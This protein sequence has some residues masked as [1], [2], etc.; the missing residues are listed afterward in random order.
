M[1]CDQA[2]LE[3]SLSLLSVESRNLLSSLLNTKKVLTHVGP[4]GITRQRDW[5]GL[6][7]LANITNELKLSIDT[8]C[9]DKVGKVLELWIDMNDG[10]AT[11][12]NLL[13]HLE[14][15]DRFDVQDDLK[16]LA[17]EDKLLDDVESDIITVEDKT[18]GAPQ[19][20][21][22]YVLYAQEDRE[23]FEKLRKNVTDEGFS[24]CSEDNLLPGYASRYQPLSRLMLL[25]CRHII[26]I[27]SPDFLRTPALKFFMNLAQADGITN[28][29]NLKLIPVMFRECV[30][31]EHLRFYHNLRY[32]YPEDKAP[33]NFWKKL[34]DTLGPV[35]LNSDQTQ[36]TTAS[37][38]VI[39]ELTNETNGFT[40]VKQLHPN[41]I[42]M[43]TLTLPSIPN[44]SVSLGDLRIDMKPEVT[45]LSH[46]SLGG[47]KK[48]LKSIKNFFFTPLKPFR[49]SKAEKQKEIVVDN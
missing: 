15:I 29:K 7:S 38:E 30:L 27:Y 28:R 43:N 34:N 35:D 14:L 5:R 20:Y 31:P 11:V 8:Q 16:T 39:S 42:N 46:S 22:A 41:G 1:N 2:V 33:F 18:F 36:I 21:H 49:R 48:K 13:K 37:S 47:R 32:T 26:L 6:A 44:E 3:A 24:V 19:Q 9:K 25:R 4:D 40:P 10:T 12:Q 17:I 23:F 45:S